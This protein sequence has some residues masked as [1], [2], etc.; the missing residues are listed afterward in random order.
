MF[1]MIF[2]TMQ[3]EQ[4]YKMMMNTESGLLDMIRIKMNL[5]RDIRFPMDGGYSN[6]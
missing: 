6:G 2:E 1:K 5:V 4:H 3:Q